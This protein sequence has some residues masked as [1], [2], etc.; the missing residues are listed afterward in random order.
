MSLRG[1]MHVRSGKW[2]GMKLDE[3]FLICVIIPYPFHMGVF[4]ETRLMKTPRYG[5]QSNSNRRAILRL[6][7]HHLY[8]DPLPFFGTP[9]MRHSRLGVTSRIPSRRAVTDQLVETSDS[10][11]HIVPGY[12]PTSQVS[13]SCQEHA[14]LI[15]M[16][17]VP[18]A[19]C[20]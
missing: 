16:V 10:V 8:I 4:S 2:L 6:V 14:V 15:P 7:V 11:N 19:R 13:V 20:Q 5:K 18:P 9:R 1:K 12:P 17:H 3:D